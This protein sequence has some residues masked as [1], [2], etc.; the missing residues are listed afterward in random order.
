MFKNY[1]K[2]AYRN[3]WKQKTSTAISIT[4]LATG[5]ACCMLIFIYIKDELGFNTFNTNLQN[6]YGLNWIT[7]QADGQVNIQA[8][9]PLPLSPAISPKIP[10]IQAATRLY[11][12]AGEMQA[13][14]NTNNAPGTSRFQEQNVYFADNALFSIFTIPFIRGSA[15][16]AITAPNTTVITDEMARKYFGTVNAVGKTLLYEN[17]QLL[18]ITGVVKKMPAAS[19]VTFDFLINLETL[20]SVEPANAADFIKT[21][22]TYTPASTYF[23]L[24]PG[25]QP[26]A[27]ETQLNILLKKYGNDRNRQMNTLALQPFKKIHLYAADVESNLST[28]S[29]TYVYIFAG[30]ALLILC[31]ANINFINLAIAHSVSRTRE[32]GMRKVLGASK[33]QLV[34]QFLNEALL[35]SFIAFALAFLLSCLGLPILNQLTDKQLSWQLFFNVPNLLL[36]TGIFFLVS[37]GAGLYP[38]FFITRFKPA[39]SIK[40][41]TGETV[42]RNT[43]RKAL[44]VAQFAISTALI[45]G[46]AV[47]YQQLQYL[48]NK[49]LGFKKEQMMVVPIF[50]S[51]N[52][53][54]SNLSLIHI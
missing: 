3:L 17:R 10:G 54:V 33:K 27:I 29:I 4:G 19:D 15:T 24:K 8:A 16:A 1:F 53:G 11:Q 7:R 45:I 52:S 37:V 36:F 34:I 12:R 6:I 13:G 21:N 30:I 31:I 48:Q 46:A 38:A 2:I 39:V 23:L 28:H 49:P 26:A 14:N 47:I 41:K 51:G 25:Q 50:G 9:S 43:I 40:G 44:L 18:Q 20:Y 5:M 42:Q 22:W 32:V 35:V